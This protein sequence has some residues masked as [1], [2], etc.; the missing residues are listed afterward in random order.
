MGFKAHE[1]LEMVIYHDRDI[2]VAEWVIRCL[3]NPNSDGSQNV[4]DSIIG[5]RVKRIANTQ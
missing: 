3:A 5:Q 2:G 1:D 4:I